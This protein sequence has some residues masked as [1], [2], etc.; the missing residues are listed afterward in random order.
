MSFSTTH[1]L[2]R[3]SHTFSTAL[4]YCS[5]IAGMEYSGI[6]L[7]VCALFLSLESHHLSYLSPDRN[8]EML[9]KL[10]KIGVL[11][12]FQKPICDLI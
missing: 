2:P 1:D 10:V 4:R 9:V 12:T 11:G 6:E 3:R 8:T 7:C 5:L